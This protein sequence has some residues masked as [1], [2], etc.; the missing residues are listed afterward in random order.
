MA[1]AS[2][3]WTAEMSACGAVDRCS[4]TWA[5]VPTGWSPTCETSPRT[6]PVRSKRGR[7][8]PTWSPMLAVLPRA[9]HRVLDGHPR[10]PAL[11]LDAAADV[12]DRVEGRLDGGEGRLD[13]ALVVEAR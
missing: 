11:V 4:A 10:E 3:T 13:G 5:A 1:S 2:S 8:R 7:E 6:R 9:A 12:R